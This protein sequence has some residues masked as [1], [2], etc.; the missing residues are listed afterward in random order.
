MFIHFPNL[1]LLRSQGPESIPGLQMQGRDK[2]WVDTNTLKI[3][4][5]VIGELSTLGFS[6]N[7]ASC[8]TAL[9]HNVDDFKH[10]TMPSFFP[11]G[12]NMLINH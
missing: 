2:P 3:I 10:T 4:E 8:W 11:Y 12:T 9:Q 7:L 6:A 5:C 1:S